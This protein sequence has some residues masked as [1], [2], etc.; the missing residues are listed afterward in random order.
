MK[1]AALYDIHANL[2][3]LEAVLAD[4]RATDV[5]LL[6]IGGD[7]VPGPMPRDAIDRVLGLEIPVEFICGNGDREVLT[8]WRGG[9]PETVPAAFRDL[10]RWNAAQLT[11][12]QADAIAS[13][14]LLVRRTIAGVGE[15]VFCHATPRNDIEIFVET[16]VEE[17]LLPLFDGLSADLVVCGH[18][19]MP[20]DRRIGKTRVVNAGSVGM[21]FGHTGASWLLLDGAVELRR[22]LFDLET[23][24]ARIRETRYPDAEAF[25]ASYVLASP[26]AA[27][28]RDLLRS[29]ELDARSAPAS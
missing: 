1:V 5:D 3:A 10:V 21:P 2:P 20:F 16:T 9:E 25:A 22:T 12:Q 23:A 8:V 6:V 15:V 4:V 13:W 14:P 7:V 24:A 27:T 18:T 28:M 19:H 11:Q 17:R 29:A 26:A